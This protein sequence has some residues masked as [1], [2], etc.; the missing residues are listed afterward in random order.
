MDSSHT[1]LTRSKVS[2]KIG[3]KLYKEAD[4][5]PNG[6]LPSKH[7]IV[8]FMM[9]LLKPIRAGAFNRSRDDAALMLSHALIDHWEFCN[10]YTI[11]FRYVKKK[12]LDLYSKFMNIKK[13][14]KSNDTWI[15]KLS[16]YN[17]NMDTLFDI[18]CTDDNARKQ[19]E[20]R[21]GIKMADGEVTFLEN[22]RTSRTGYCLEQ[23]DR[24][25]ERTM[26]RKLR[27]EMHLHQERMNES[28]SRSVSGVEYE[29]SFEDIDQDVVEPEENDNNHYSDIAMEAEDGIA[30]PSSSKKNRREFTNEVPI[31]QTLE[32][33]LPSEFRHLRSNARVLK[34]EFYRVI[35]KLMSVYHC[36]YS[37]ALAEIIET[38]NILFSRNWKYSD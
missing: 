36:S 15:Q 3:D 23:V 27:Q 38:G 5:L 26:Q 24:K 4:G 31:E 21:F 19:K 37:Q 30:G 14:Q 2:C 7:Q 35:D 6:I 8:E 1:L 18:Y 29:K 32:D 33:T 28:E 22:M 11:N 9:Y 13:N 16:I 20:T 12:I 25:W 10:V 17:E 34:P